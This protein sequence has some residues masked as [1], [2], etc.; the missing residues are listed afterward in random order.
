[1]SDERGTGAELS[2]A[3]TFAITTTPEGYQYPKY[4]MA[5]PSHYGARV[6]SNRR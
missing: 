6:P 1:M 4:V 3:V 5:G 2:E